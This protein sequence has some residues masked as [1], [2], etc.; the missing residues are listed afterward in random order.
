MVSNSSI[1]QPEQATDGSLP[2]GKEEPAADSY[3]FR[4]EIA[5]SILLVLL[6]IILCSIPDDLS[7]S[8]GANLLSAGAV[9]LL[10]F[11]VYGKLFR[12]RRQRLS[13][14]QSVLLETIA[15]SCER[16]EKRA[17]VEAIRVQQ[18]IAD[19]VPE[20]VTEFHA[21]QEVGLQGVDVGRPVHEI[22]QAVL[23]AQ[24]TVDILEVSLKTMQDID[25]SQWRACKANVRIILL[26]PR[27]PEDRPLAC[28]RD[29]EEEQT[30][31]QIL[32]E[33]HEILDRF[34]P[35][36]LSSE[37][38]GPPLQRVK[39]A[40]VMPT[41]SYFRVDDVAYFAPLLHK[42]L[43]HVAIHL[44]LG[45]GGKLFEA[46]AKHFETLWNDKKRIVTVRPGDIPRDYPPIG[47]G[48]VL[49]QPPADP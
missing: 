43:G 15:A 33:I 46:L 23:Q 5:A 39:L 29:S 17:T 44:R 6:G 38:G 18:A 49:K 16:A 42:Q 45:K 12:K 27:F 31:G 24:K 35:E 2:G 14:E 21:A 34:P 8:I 26:D 4:L 41:V 22:N 36:W 40:Q 10:V 28:Q 7:K 19:G 9:G 48:T 37:D 3:E 13:A 11:F 30:D 47:R 32:K 1:D 25:D 20:S